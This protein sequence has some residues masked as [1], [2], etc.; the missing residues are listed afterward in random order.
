MQETSETTPPHLTDVQIQKATVALVNGETATARDLLMQV[1]EYDETNVAAWWLLSRVVE[2]ADEREICLEN[3]LT[4]DP[5]HAAARAAWEQLQ[6]D[7]ASAAATFAERS[8]TSVEAA[9]E[10]MPPPEEL[11]PLPPTPS[12]PDFLE[13]ELGCPYCA[14]PTAWED[15][16]CPA[17]KHSLWTHQR[18]VEQSTPA[19]RALLMLEVLFIGVSALLLLL[20][21]TYVD[22]CV[23]SADIRDLA[24]LYLGIKQIAPKI[25]TASFNFVPPVLFRLSLLPIG[26]SLIILLGLLS[27]WAPLYFTALLIEAL[28]ILVN[29]STIIGAINAWSAT[30]AAVKTEA[31]AGQLTGQALSLMHIVILLTY[32]AILAL[33]GLSFISL[34]NLHDHFT[35]KHRRLLLR[36]DAD[37]DGSIVGLQIRG[38]AYAHQYAWA[39][40]ALHLRQAWMLEHNLETGLALATVYLNLGRLD[41]AA[42]AL[43]D[44]RRLAPTDPRIASLTAILAEKQAHGKPPYAPSP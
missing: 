34:L 32:L 33:A 22:I 24:P 11:A 8:Y 42:I 4:L 1:I 36:T 19:Y 6:R 44:A 21:L 40:A 41:L 15:K 13:D 26:L 38:R 39:L 7:K 23:K 18:E 3:I 10:A 37:V 43:E 16:R 17:C 28:R 9:P 31:A 27:R 20:L 29:L 35:F 12:T 2:T 14:A 30:A 5:N 25:A